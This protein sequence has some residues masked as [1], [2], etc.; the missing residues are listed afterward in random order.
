MLCYHLFAMIQTCTYLYS[1]K[2]SLKWGKHRGES[3]PERRSGIRIIAGTAF[4]L[5]FLVGWYYD[6]NA[7]MAVP[8][9]Y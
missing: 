7:T 5:E 6:A 4:R 1:S 8:E 2:Y 3:K 9:L